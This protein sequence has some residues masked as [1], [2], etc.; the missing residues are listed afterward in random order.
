MVRDLVGTVTREKADIGV[1]LT[2]T[3]PTRPMK[4]EASSAGFYKSPMG[5]MH[6]KVQILTIE[7]LLTGRGIDYPTGS[8]RS[9]TTFRRAPRINTK[10][11]VTSLFDGLPTSHVG[12]VDE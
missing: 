3:K 9:N 12:A 7:E 8:Q 2:F 11:P 4:D 1:L 10:S 5:G 6:P